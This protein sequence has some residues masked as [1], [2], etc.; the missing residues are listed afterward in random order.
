MNSFAF[1]VNGG[2]RTNSRP[3]LAP[4][5]SVKDQINTKGDNVMK[6]KSESNKVKRAA[7]KRLSS[8]SK[9]CKSK[10]NHQPGYHKPVVNPTTNYP[11][12][13]HKKF[14]VRCMARNGLGRH[15]KGCSL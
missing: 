5:C 8:A 12:D 1:D 4:W 14:C 2:S 3:G 11:P 10:T 9:L 7:A 6:T 15:C 13:S